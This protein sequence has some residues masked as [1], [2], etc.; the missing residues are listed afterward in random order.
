MRLSGDRLVGS[1]ARLL[2]ELL[3][4]L[5]RASRASSIASF[6]VRLFAEPLT[7]PAPHLSD[8]LLVDSA[9]RFLAELF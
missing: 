5:Q 4:G 8:E 1:A 7:G 6:A 3:I 9:A 2:S